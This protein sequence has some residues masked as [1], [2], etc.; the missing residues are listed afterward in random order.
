MAE[1]SRETTH[2]RLSAVGSEDTEPERTVQAVLEDWGLEFDT[3][4]KDLPGSPDLVL[5]SRQAVIF[6]HGC[7]WHRHDGC[8]LAADPSKNEEFW[9]QKFRR[10]QERDRENRRDLEED[11]WRV[12]TVW[13]CETRSPEE[14]TAKLSDELL[15]EAEE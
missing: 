6:V 3:N 5:E 11:G 14:L 8:E 12:L 4:R 2:R 1:E 15:T 7:F 13:E 10:N 9:Q